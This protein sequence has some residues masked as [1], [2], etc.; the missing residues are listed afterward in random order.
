MLYN[1]FNGQL[2][3]DGAVMVDGVLRCRYAAD[4]T[5][6]KLENRL[7]SYTYHDT[8]TIISPEEAYGRMCSGEFY[9]GGYFESFYQKYH[10]LLAERSQD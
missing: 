6:R 7:L 2:N 10:N 8:E 5:I 1:A 9:D 3:M 4:G